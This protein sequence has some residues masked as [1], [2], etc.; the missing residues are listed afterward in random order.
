[1]KKI[2]ILGSTG[3]IGQ[4][5]LRVVEHLRDEFEVVALAASSNI[6]R[7]ASQI[8]AFRPQVVAVADRLMASKLRSM[9]HLP[10]VRILE[11]D[12][13]VVE[14]ASLQGVEVVVMAIVG[15]KA[16]RPTLAA[17]DAGKTVCLA[18]KEVLVSAGELVCGRAKEKNITLLP[19]DSEHSALFQCL[20]KE[21]RE[22]VSKLILTASGGPFRK[23]SLE[24]LHTVTV[25]DALNHPTWNMGAK[26][27]VDSSTLM[28]KGLEM[29]EAA[30]FFDFSPSQIEIVIHPQSIVHSFVEC[31]DG[32]LLAQLSPPNM[33]YPIQYAL[34]YPDRRP[35]PLPAYDITKGGVLEFYPPDFEKFPAL[36]LAYQSLEAGHS[37]PCYLNAANE[38]LVERFLQEKISWREILVKLDQLLEKHCPLKDMNSLDALLEI[39]RQARQEASQI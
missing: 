22:N 30:W 25:K 29:I 14:V 5:T 38:T 18:S 2:A 28:N 27:T 19:V 32:S 20:Q 13:G 34:T 3:S 36:T 17:I 1:M 33:I 26:I 31:V 39:D 11:G 7:L 24:Q 8:V 35:T 37:Y 15:M 6:E 4:S 10:P 12:E 9:S 16:L 23:H 21:K